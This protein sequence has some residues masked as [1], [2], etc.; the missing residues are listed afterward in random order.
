MVGSTFN[1]Y[2]KE[3][4]D[5]VTTVVRMVRD[6]PGVIMLFRIQEE[7]TIGSW[8]HRA[9][10]LGVYVC[11]YFPGTYVEILCRCWMDDSYS[12][13]ILCIIPRYW[14]MPGASYKKVFFE[15]SIFS[16][17]ECRKLQSLV[18]V[19]NNS[20]TIPALAIMA[21]GP[22]KTS[23]ITL[24]RVSHLVVFDPSRFSINIAS[25]PRRSMA[26]NSVTILA[27]AI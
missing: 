7:H 9:L 20:V 6:A 21:G 2:G 17:Q 25:L 27:L 12:Y 5:N 23:N 14:V 10:S 4:G 1:A 15:K 19:P 8:D 11:V 13:H 16:K 18:A 26:N 22:L 3:K 24:V